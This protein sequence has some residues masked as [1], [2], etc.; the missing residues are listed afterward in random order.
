MMEFAHAPIS[1]SLQP[2]VA[3]IWASGQKTVCTERIVPDGGSVLIF[4]FGDPV[5]MGAEGSTRETKKGNFFA[6]LSTSY[7]DLSYTG[8][9][10]QVGIIFKPFG[11]FHLLRLPMSELLN[12]VVDLDLINGHRFNPV[13]EAMALA[14]SAQRRLDIVSRWLEESYAD[15]TVESFVPR[16]NALLQAEDETLVTEIA[17]RLG[18]SQQH[19]ARLFNKYTGINPKKLQRIFRFQRVLHSLSTRKNQVLTEAAYEF[20]YFDQPHFNNEIKSFSGF[21]PSQLAKQNVLSSLR[22]I[23]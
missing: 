17:D 3:G 18:R 13:F 5:T 22:V 7:I 1:P 15:A 12:A 6:G 9:F 2:F 23:R 16:V 20:N 14:N 19:V 8:R 11:A 10:E 4:N 21:T